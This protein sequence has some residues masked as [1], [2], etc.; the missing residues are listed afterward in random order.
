MF[1]MVL[2]TGLEPVWYR[3]R[4]ILSPLRLP[5][6]PQQ[7]LTIILYHKHFDLSRAEWNKLHNF[8]KHTLK[9]SE[10]YVII[11]MYCEKQQIDLRT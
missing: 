10:K 1:G 7:H 4:G 11:N 2:L 3:Y 5:I 8:Q 9:S 6:S